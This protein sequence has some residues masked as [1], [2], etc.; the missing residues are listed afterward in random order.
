MD[1]MSPGELQLVRM[2][3]TVYVAN[4]AS[5]KVSVIDAATNTIAAT[6]IVGNNPRGVAV[7]SG[8]NKRYM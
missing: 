7:T 3:Q 8:W 1:L 6:V 4:S 2:E 5:N